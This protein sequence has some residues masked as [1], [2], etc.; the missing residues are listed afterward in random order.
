MAPVETATLN[1]S[2]AGA[3]STMPVAISTVRARIVFPAC[4]VA[5]KP[6]SM[7]LNALIWERTTSTSNRLACAARKREALYPICL[8]ESPDSFG[9]WVSRPLDFLLIEYRNASVISREVDGGR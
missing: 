2:I 7:G 9:S 3:L 4:V 6:P 5:L 1:P 8:W